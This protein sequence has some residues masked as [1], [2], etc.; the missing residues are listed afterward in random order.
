MKAWSSY[1]RRRV[2]HCVE[3][4]I[5]LP[6]LAAVRKVLLPIQPVQR[7]MQSIKSHGNRASMPFSTVY[8]NEVSSPVPFANSSNSFMGEGG[9]PTGGK[10]GNPL[11]SP[12]F[13]R[14]PRTAFFRQTSIPIRK[15]RNS[16]LSWGNQGREKSDSFDDMNTLSL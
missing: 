5:S 13:A 12:V 2:Y 9:T 10:G 14:N 11:L 16:D 7:R 6:F 3:K 8:G 1:E 15:S 4:V